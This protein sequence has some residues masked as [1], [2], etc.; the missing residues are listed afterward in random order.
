MACFTCSVPCDWCEGYLAG[1][2]ERQVDVVKE[3]CD[4]ARTL[5]GDEIFEVARQEFRGESKYVEWLNKSR[6]VHGKK[7]M[8]CFALFER[9]C[10]ARKNML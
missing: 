9:I 1:K 3:V 2:C 8:N 6:I 10:R 4:F 5:F 7:S